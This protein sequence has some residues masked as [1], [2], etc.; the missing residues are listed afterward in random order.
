MQRRRPPY[1]GRVRWRMDNKEIDVDEK[2]R[3]RENKAR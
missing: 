1:V 3:R 2:I